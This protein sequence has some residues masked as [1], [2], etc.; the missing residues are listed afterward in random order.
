MKTKTLS[1]NLIITTQKEFDEIPLN[2]NGKIQIKDTKEFIDINHS[3]I[4]AY[5]NVSGNSTIKNVSGN[6]TIK[7]VSGNATIES[8]YDNATIESVYDNVIIKNVY[9]NS[10][11][12]YVYD[13][14]IIKNVYGNATT[15]YVS[16]NSTIKSVSGNATTKYV[17][18]NSTIK[19]VSGNATIES[20]YDNVIIKNVYDNA[21]IES[22]YDNV[23]IKNV[24]DN[25]TIEYVYDN[26]IIKYVYDN[27]TIKSV[28]DNVIIKNVYGNATIE[29]VSGNVIIENMIGLSSIVSLYSAKQIIAKGMNLIRQIGINE[30]DLDLGENVNFIQ[31]ENT[32]KKDTTFD[33]YSKLYPVEIKGKKAILYKA[34]HKKDGVYFSEYD[35]NFTYT[36]GKIKEEYIDKSKTN[37]CSSGIHLAYLQWAKLFGKYWED[38]AI[39]ECETNIEDIIVSEDCDGKVRSSK[40]KI[41]RELLE[42]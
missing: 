37:S 31:V 32:I 7:S 24:Y 23:I 16:G 19:S 5:I 6:S 38:L 12:E 21:T 2:Y 41:I 15:K 9:D 29:S 33:M 27:A 25:S 36:I 11:I 40:V 8:V 28:Y 3:F 20:V 17:S 26:V 4:D 10:T 1:K 13:N 35:N 39:L 22:V 34:V 30:I 42:Y 14:V 18:G